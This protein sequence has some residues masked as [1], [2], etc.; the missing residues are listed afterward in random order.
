MEVKKTRNQENQKKSEERIIRNI[1]TF[2]E[3]EED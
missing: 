2:L 3:Q 1:K